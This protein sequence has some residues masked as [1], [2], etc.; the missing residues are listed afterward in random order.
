MKSLL[1]FLVGIAGGFVVAHFMNKDPRGH[2]ILAEV[3]GR[4]TEVG[5]VEL[6]CIAEDT[7]R[8][9]KLELQLRGD[10]SEDLAAT[11]ITQLHPR[12]REATDL[13]KEVYGKSARETTGS[14]LLLR[15]G[16]EALVPRLIE[17]VDERLLEELLP[18]RE[19]VVDERGRGTGSHR[20]PG[21][22]DIVDPLLRDQVARGL[23]D[24]VTRVRLHLPNVPV[25]PDR[26][27]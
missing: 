6:S 1:W 13:I 19:V 17:R 8:R 5:T 23:E 9:W 12:F 11:K 2:E 16:G 15:L 20:H 21:D 4:I 24:P 22:A 26:N 14:G 27:R 7:N 25:G 3:D 18:G 10:A